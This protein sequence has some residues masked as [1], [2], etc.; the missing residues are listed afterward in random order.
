MLTEDI[1]VFSCRVLSVHQTSNTEYLC[2]IVSMGTIKSIFS[3]LNWHPVSL[4]GDWEQHII[5]ITC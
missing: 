1:S 3:L 4:K 5:R 2:H